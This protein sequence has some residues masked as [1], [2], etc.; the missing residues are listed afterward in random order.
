MRMTWAWML[1]ATMWA[2]AGCLNLPLF[3]P[4]PKPVEVAPAS[5]PPRPTT[6]VTADQVTETNAREKAQ[7]LKAELEREEVGD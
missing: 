5:P 1:L 3:S 7:A 4:P 6:P 2:G